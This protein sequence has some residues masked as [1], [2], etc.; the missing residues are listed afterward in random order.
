VVD[1]EING[2]GGAETKGLS[3]TSVRTARPHNVG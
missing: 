2:R 3:P 1:V